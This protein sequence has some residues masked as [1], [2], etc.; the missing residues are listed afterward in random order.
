MARKFVPPELKEVHSSTITKIGWEAETLFVVFNSNQKIC[1]TYANVP[2]KL[3]QL[4]DDA[5]YINQRIE[6]LT[7]EVSLGSLF[8]YLIKIHP[9]KYPFEKNEIA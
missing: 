2:K 7:R 3:F 1:Y 5:D 4:L 8:H 9:D 6:P